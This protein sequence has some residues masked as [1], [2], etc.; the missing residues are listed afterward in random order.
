MQEEEDTEPA[1]LEFE[2]HH[3][4]KGVGVYICNFLFLGY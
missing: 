2:E 4:C 3:T 1:E